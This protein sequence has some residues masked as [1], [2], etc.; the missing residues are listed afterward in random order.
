VR[1]LYP[2]G[3]HDFIPKIT[4]EGWFI[5]R[6]TNDIKVHVNNRIG[7]PGCN[8]GLADKCLGCNFVFGGDYNISKGC[9]NNR[10]C[11]I[12]NGFCQGNSFSW[13]DPVP[14]GW[15]RLHIL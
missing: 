9:C 7:N 3:T 10:L 1:S 15:N 12:L 6:F 13:L 4:I 5:S 14:C 11:D 2:Q 8:A